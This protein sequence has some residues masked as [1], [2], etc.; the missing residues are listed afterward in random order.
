MNSFACPKGYG[1]QCSDKLDGTCTADCATCP[2]IGICSPL[3]V[4]YDVCPEWPKRLEEIMARRP[5]CSVCAAEGVL[6]E[7]GCQGCQER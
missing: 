2:S 4:C 6:R 1:W 3:C 5:D 7:G